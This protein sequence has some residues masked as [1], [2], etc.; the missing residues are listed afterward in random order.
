MAQ[1][2]AGQQITDNNSK[3]RGNIDDYKHHEGE[4]VKIQ[5][6]IRGRQARKQFA[7][8]KYYQSIL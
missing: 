8:G 3:N 7:T 5:S 2:A 6:H 1:M 4:I